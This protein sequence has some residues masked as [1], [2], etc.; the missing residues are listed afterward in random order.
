MMHKNGSRNCVEPGQ[1]NPNTR[2]AESARISH[3]FG[4]ISG[5]K[6]DTWS[7]WRCEF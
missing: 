1:P 4:P 7:D 3:R 6:F 5:R 2:G